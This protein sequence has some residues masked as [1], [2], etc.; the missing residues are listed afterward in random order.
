MAGWAVVVVV[1]IGNAQALSFG[2]QRLKT[3]EV[4]A[5]EKGSHVK[6]VSTRS[7][8]ALPCRYHKKSAWQ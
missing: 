6:G 2:L 1:A 3:L 4:A 5:E 7:P 8:A